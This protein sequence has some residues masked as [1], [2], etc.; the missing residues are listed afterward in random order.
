VRRSRSRTARRSSFNDVLEEFIVT[1]RVRQRFP[2]TQLHPA[3]F[4]A[5][6]DIFVVTTGAVPTRLRSRASPIPVSRTIGLSSRAPLDAFVPTRRQILNVGFPLERRSSATGEAFPLPSLELPR[7]ACPHNGFSIV[8][9]PR[10]ASAQRRMKPHKVPQILCDATNPGPESAISSLV[11][12]SRDVVD[13][14]FAA[15]PAQRV[16]ELHDLDEMSCSRIDLVAAFL[17]ALSRTQ[18]I[19]ASRMPR[20][21]LIGNA[22]VRTRVL[23]GSNRGRG[24]LFFFCIGEPIPS[25]DIDISIP[26]LGIAARG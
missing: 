13:Q 7:I 2:R 15:H 8:L 10:T 11:I 6:N 3:G 16:L 9:P 26:S 22:R 12:S 17:G 18:S 1:T 25:E 5:V 23:R 14:I 19:L 21:A 20:Y 24:V 4:D